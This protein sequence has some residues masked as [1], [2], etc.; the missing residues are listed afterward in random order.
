MTRHPEDGPDRGV[1]E[2]D[3]PRL[4]IVVSSA[5]VSPWLEI[6]EH[7]Q[8]PIIRRL[9]GDTAQVIWMEGNRDLRPLLRFRAL[10]WL[11]RQQVRVMYIKSGWFRRLYKN[12]W[13]KYEWNALGAGFMRALFNKNEPGFLSSSSSRRIRRNLPIQMSLA[14]IR[15]LDVLRYC[16][17]HYQFDYLLRITSSCLP[18][19][20]E[21]TKVLKNLPRARVYG[22][23][24][25]TFARTDFVSGAAV[26]MSRDVV[27]GI[28]KH[29]DAFSFL[30]FED[31]ALGRIVKRKNLADLIEI[32]RIDVSSTSQVPVGF[33]DAWPQAP[34][35]RCKAESPVTTQSAPVVDIMKAVVPHLDSSFRTQL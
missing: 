17:Q 18:V 6:E 15:T 34:V 2:E 31:V 22:G 25:S 30:V 28:W 35:V 13:N 33:D 3:P 32:P 9:M 16:S 24:K 19:P 27:D 26:L 23:V 5:G 20:S 8:V 7:A 14:G 12:Y 11:V 29:A 4:L 1:P 21:L 10:D